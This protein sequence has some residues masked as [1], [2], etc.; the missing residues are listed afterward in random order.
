[1]ATQAAR[2][3]SPCARF[4]RAHP[5]A[6]RARSTGM[7][8]PRLRPIALAIALTALLCAAPAR[9]HDTWFAPLPA[10]APGSVALAL[11]TG[12]HFPVQESGIEARYLV[13][14]GC[15]H[16]PAGPVIALQPI[17]NSATALALHVKSASAQPLS[18][19]AQTSAFD[20]VLE[21]SK[22]A[23]Y[24][25]D[26]QASASVREAWARMS[27]RGVPWQERY[28][29]HARIELQPGASAA[30]PVEMAMDVLFEAP[31]RTPRSGDA[32]QFRVLRDGRPLP[33]FAVELRGDRSPIGLWSKTDA[34][35]RVRFTAPLPGRWVVRGT[36]LRLSEHEPDLWVSRFVT[37][38]F[39]VAAVQ[40]D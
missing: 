30:A 21:P 4:G 14:S 13:H 12:N 38:A 1:M 26:I 34:E 22:I 29:K 7:D 8:H 20:V 24:L 32:L 35:G 18:C 16:D 33:D 25:K 40:R 15:R 28:T 19:W 11:G 10:Q 6:A 17:G 23:V 37:L 39:D 5:L 9:A 27:A 36:D 2:S 3:P 31:A